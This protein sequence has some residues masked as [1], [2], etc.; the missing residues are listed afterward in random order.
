MAMTLRQTIARLKHNE[1]SSERRGYGGDAARVAFQRHCLELLNIIAT[2]PKRKLS[3]YQLKIGKYLKQ[4]KSL[5][6]AHRLA[7]K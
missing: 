4:G 3:A 7:K 5:K 1:E 6:E 2:K